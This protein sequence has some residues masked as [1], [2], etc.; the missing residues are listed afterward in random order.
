MW[1]K[2]KEF[3]SKQHPVMYQDTGNQI[4]QKGEIPIVR[5]AGTNVSSVSRG[6]NKR[7]NVGRKRLK[8]P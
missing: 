2:E 7:K 5:T 1:A 8:A 6:T 4:F 3:K